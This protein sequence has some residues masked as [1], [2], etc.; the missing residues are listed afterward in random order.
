MTIDEFQ[1][2][3]RECGLVSTDGNDICRLTEMFALCWK[4]KGEAL[5]FDAGRHRGPKLSL[6]KL[7]RT[8]HCFEKKDLDL[9]DDEGW[10]WIGTVVLL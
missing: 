10:E 7:N 9:P 2:D 3:W 8:D 1:R 6:L 4:K 5:L